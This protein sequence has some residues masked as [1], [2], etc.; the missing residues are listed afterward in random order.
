MKRK[1]MKGKRQPEYDKKNSEKSTKKRKH[2][3]SGK[4]FQLRKEITGEEDK[5]RRL[6]IKQ[7]KEKVWEKWKS[8][9]D[10]V[11]KTMKKEK[12]K[13]EQMEL[14]LKKIDR[15]RQKS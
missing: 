13:M 8:R 3:K 15:V 2:R 6:D 11:D 4:N 1:G 10:K 14:R 5:F 12:I 7:A 9:D